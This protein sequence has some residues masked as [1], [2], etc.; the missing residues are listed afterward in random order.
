M[1]HHSNLVPWQ[2]LAA[3][4]GVRLRFLDVDEQGELSLDQARAMIGPRTRI[5]SVTQMSNVL[6]TITRSRS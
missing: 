5:V 3:R 4:R 6:G 1:E 2:L